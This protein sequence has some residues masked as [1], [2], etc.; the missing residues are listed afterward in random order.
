MPV[1]GR[2]VDVQPVAEAPGP[3]PIV[4]EPETAVDVS[5]APEVAKPTDV[6]PTTEAE[7]TEVPTTPT[8]P[9]PAEASP[10]PEEIVE[11][12]LPRAEPKEPGPRP[13]IV[14]LREFQ[15]KKPALMDLCKAYDPDP[16]GTTEQLR[17]R[18]L[19]Y[20]DTV[21]EEAEPELDAEGE[22]PAGPILIERPEIES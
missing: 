17:E 3:A 19:S 13:P 10:Q 8:T 11:E 7:T 20:L 18:L 12:E 6:E 1:D 21:E 4:T 22:A 2:P 16:T 15:A 9:A 5:E 14:R